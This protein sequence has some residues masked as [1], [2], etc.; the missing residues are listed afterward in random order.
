MNK[1]S[2]ILVNVILYGILLWL[3][4]QSIVVDRD[5][6]FAFVVV[7]LLL[8]SVVISLVPGLRAPGVSPGEYPY[9]D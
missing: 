8:L 1:L 6:W 2:Q 5:P 4:H 9:D 3:A 7:F